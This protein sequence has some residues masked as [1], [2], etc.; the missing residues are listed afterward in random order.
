MSNIFWI[1]VLAFL[2]AGAMVLIVFLMRLNRR[3]KKI[4]AELHEEVIIRKGAE[5]AAK[6]SERTLQAINDS[7]KDGV[8]FADEDGVVRSVNPFFC[9]FIGTPAEKIIGRTLKELHLEGVQ[10]FLDDYL[11]KGRRGEAGVFEKERELAGRDV[12]LRV[13]PVVAQGRFLGMTLNVFDITERKHAEQELVRA[14]EAADKANRAKSEFLANMSHEI[15]TP[16]NGVIGMTELALDTDLTAEQ[17]DF[18]TAVKHSADAL[19]QIINDILDFSRIEAGGVEL[20]T[21]DFDLRNVVEGVSGT[22]AYRASNAGLTMEVMIE[23]DTPCLL[24]GDPGRLRQVIVNLAGNAIKFTEKGGVEISVSLEK[25]D[26]D[27]ATLLFSIRDTGIGIPQDS[28]ERIFESFVQVDGSTARKYGGT[29]LGLTISRNLVELMGGRIEVESEVGKGS[30]FRFSARFAKGKNVRVALPAAAPSIEG[31]KVLVIDDS[32]ANRLIVTKSLESFKCRPAAASGGREGIDALKAA[33]AANDPF[34]L[35]ILDMQMPGMDG[36]S[37]ARVIK[38]DP[39]IRDVAIIVLTSVGQRGDVARLGKIGIAGYMMKP[40]KQSLLLAIMQGVLGKLEERSKPGSFP[41]ITRHT[42]KEAALQNVHVLLAEDNKINQMVAVRLLKKRGYR[43]TVVDNGKKALLALEAKAFDLVLMDVQMPEMDGLAATR[44]I[45]ETE[46]Q[47]GGHIPIVAMTAHAMKGDRERCIAAGMDDYVS[48]PLSAGP[49]FDT[50]ARF[51]NPEEEPAG[52]PAQER[53]CFPPPPEPPVA[54]PGGD[55]EPGGDE[56]LSLDF[57][58][59][60]FEG[61]LDFA[62][63]LAEIY[64][65]DTP[66]RMKEIEQAI[67]EGRPEAVCDVAHG[68]KGASG[69]FGIQVLHEAFAEL[70]RLGSEDLEKA[71]A[72]WEEISGLWPRVESVLKRLWEDDK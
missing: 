47:A 29:G 40:L 66:R 35:V 41:V 12:S 36:E 18:L 13:Q 2:L 45:R 21:I 56:I 1:L 31:V 46:K 7:M 69:N 23:P 61:D 30:T 22:F 9:E 60:K 50:L 52:P 6:R 20:D 37:T 70:E 65:S 71:R 19:L 24:R 11:E 53:D 10:E 42:I 44:A 62:R 26:P 16:L 33:K 54:D 72:R 38:E 67:S 5:D 27:E 43:T 32:R 63:E 58:K 14:K 34:R 64:L 25:E 17:R 59:E 68:L 28:I 55:A 57:V 15:R 4:R 8:V 51:F 48:K 3:L 49:F 39:E